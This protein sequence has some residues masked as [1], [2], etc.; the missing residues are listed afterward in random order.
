MTALLIEIGCEE[1]PYK[2]CESVV[3]QLEGTLRVPGLVHGLLAEE[4]L[5]PAPRGAGLRRPRRLSS[6]SI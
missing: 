3:G 5:L 1:L 4:R 2:V 6:Q